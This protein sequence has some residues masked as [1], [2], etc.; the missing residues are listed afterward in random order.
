MALLQAARIT[1]SQGNITL[2]KLDN[3]I[4]SIE[5]ARGSKGIH[6]A[7]SL[8]DEELDGLRAIREDMR[9]EALPAS[10]VRPPGSDTV[11]NLATSNALG[12]YLGNTAVDTI[13]GGL[14]G[15]GFDLYHGNLPG[16]AAGVGALAG[17]GVKRALASKDAQVLD[18]LANRLLNP[19]AI[20]S[21]LQSPGLTRVMVNGPVRRNAIPVTATNRLL[22]PASNEAPNGRN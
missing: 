13:G 10:K 9:R 17:L 21:A 16:T 20:P 1:D 7:K 3:T 5:K 4:K 15:A 11:Q 6:A 12:R 18:L 8:T 19:H 14:L 22:A 2:A